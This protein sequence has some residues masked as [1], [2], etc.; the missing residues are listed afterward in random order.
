MHSKKSKIRRDLTGQRFGRLIV[1]GPT[2]RR[3]PGGHVIWD[4]V[5]DCTKRKCISSQQLL[6]R[7]RPTISCGCAQTYNK[8]DPNRQKKRCSKCGEIKSI[9]DF[10]KS[11]NA[12]DGHICYCK[13][14]WST[15]Q[16]ERAPSMRVKKNEQSN[17]RYRENINHRLA[18]GMRNRTRQALRNHVKAGKTLEMLGC[19]IDVLKAY[20]E[21][22]FVE[23]MTWDNYGSMWELDH[24]RPCASFDLVDPEQQR[25]CFHYTN[26]Q[27]M[28]GIDNRRKGDRYDPAA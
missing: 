26:L 12:K 4:C 17:R 24:I 18:H 16:K 6:A 3:G 14:C 27:P 22:R 9:D 7:T 5:C 11:K 8:I 1:L 15:I 13:P 10:N 25:V 2:E 21:E 19:S 28:K 20:L 23:G